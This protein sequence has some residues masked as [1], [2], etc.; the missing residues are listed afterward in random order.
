MDRWREVE[1][2]KRKKEG[3]SI[4]VLVV[5]RREGKVEESKIKKKGG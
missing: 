2:K 4:H 3:G 5:D 1:G